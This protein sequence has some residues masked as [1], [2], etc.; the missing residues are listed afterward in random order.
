MKTISG[1][2]ISSQPISHSRAFKVLKKFVPS[3]DTG[4]SRSISAHLRRTL[5]AFRELD[6]FHRELKPLRSKHQGKTQRSGATNSDGTKEAEDNHRELSVKREVFD[7]NGEKD[8]G[9]RK[10][11]KKQKKSDSKGGLNEVQSHM[12]IEG[13]MKNMKNVDMEDS[14]D[15]KDGV[16]EDQRRMSVGE[17]KRKRKKSVDA[18][19]AQP[20]DSK[21]GVKSVEVKDTPPDESKDGVSGIHSRMIIEGKMKKIKSVDVKDA[22]D[23]K[24][25]VRGVKEEETKK[26]KIVDVEDAQQDDSASQH[27]K[28]KKRRRIE[29]DA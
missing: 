10:E 28:K 8:T 24:D 15:S 21:D 12:V 4:A 26:R 18:K 9:I 17:G 22:H 29:G 23:S 25:G 14:R 11:K 13:N 6:G 19:D 7:G 3:G 2:V 5:E 16:L 20:D 27:S 1:K